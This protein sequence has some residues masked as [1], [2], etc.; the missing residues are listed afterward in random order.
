[1]TNSDWWARAKTPPRPETI[2]IR[3][4]ECVCTLRK[5]RYEATLETHVVHGVG[6]E[7][8]FSIDGHWRRMRVFWSGRD[9]SL[10]EAIARYGDVAGTIW[11]GL[12][13]GR[14][15]ISAS[16]SL[17]PALKRCRG[18]AAPSFCGLAEK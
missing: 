17:A 9:P 4:R 1:V 11:M 12:R 3:P 10:D 6:R 7:L 2:S 14:L 13:P 15:P 16:D 18:R 5:D 8:I